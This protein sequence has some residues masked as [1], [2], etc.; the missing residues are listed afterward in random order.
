MKKC[1]LAVSVIAGL[2]LVAPGSGYAQFHVVPNQV[3]IYQFS[4]GTGSNC[5]YDIGAPVTLYLVLTKPTDEQNGDTPYTTINAF[6]CMLEFTVILLATTLALNRARV[7]AASR[8]NSRS[9]FR[10]RSMSYCDI[11]ACLV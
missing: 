8:P 10:K 4:D 2:S 9:R 7:R 11:S 5:T 6:E 3:G 1:L